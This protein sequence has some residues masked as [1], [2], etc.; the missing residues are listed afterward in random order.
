MNAAT[1]SAARTLSTSTALSRR[2]GNHQP[3]ARYVQCGARNANGGRECRYWE[4]LCA[5]GMYRRARPRSIVNS[6]RR[7]FCQADVYDA[8]VLWLVLGFSGAVWRN[9]RSPLPF[10]RYR[11][12]RSVFLASTRFVLGSTRFLQSA[13][14]RLR[15]SLTA[16]AR[17]SAVAVDPRSDG[18]CPR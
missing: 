6:T 15:W 4:F 14:V 1:S 2:S 8:Y 3:S 17:I 18:S 7:D 11:C 13:S 5:I 9:E 12:L 16:S 10:D